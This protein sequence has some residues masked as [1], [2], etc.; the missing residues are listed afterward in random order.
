MA[1]TRLTKSMREDIV[2]ALKKRAF[3]DRRETVREMESDLAMAVYHDLYS[4]KELEHMEALGNEFFEC[5]GQFRVRFGT[6]GS[7]WNDTRLRFAYDEEERQYKRHRFGHQHRY[8][9]ANYDASHRL[10][11]QALVW[12]KAKEKLDENLQKLEAELEA[13]LETCTTLKKFHALWPEAKVVTEEMGLKETYLSASEML[14]AIP[15][16]MNCVL[17][18]VSPEDCAGVD[19]DKVPE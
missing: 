17:G 15:R 13:I 19:T 11:E 12:H 8:T 7:S 18:L 16:D 3:K 14:P 5:E 6:I 9:V 10:S 1:S 2:K 4:I